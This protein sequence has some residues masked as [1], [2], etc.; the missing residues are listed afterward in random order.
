[1]KLLNQIDAK[2]LIIGVL[3]TLVV[4]LA[5]GARDG[6]EKEE[7]DN[8]QKWALM[9]IPLKD[10]MNR[11]DGFTTNQNGGNPIYGWAPF[12]ILDDKLVVKRIM[13]R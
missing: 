12:C 11:N 2:S 5:M 4:T 6:K 8:S 9:T 1:M 7:W 3:L 13:D 10:N